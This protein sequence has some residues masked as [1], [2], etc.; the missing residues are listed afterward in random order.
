M[1]SAVKRYVTL[2][3]ALRQVQAADPFPAV[4]EAAEAVTEVV[5]AH[6]TVLATFQTPGG[7]EGVRGAGGGADGGDRG[8]PRR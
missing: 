3:G 6:V 1:G 4:A 8:N 2:W 5:M 7:A